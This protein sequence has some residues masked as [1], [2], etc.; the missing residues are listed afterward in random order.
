MILWPLSG[1]AIQE[2][3]KFTDISQ[4]PSSVLTPL[5]PVLKDARIEANVPLNPINWSFV[6]DGRFAK[7]CPRI[8]C[9]ECK[10]E[11]FSNSEGFG[12]L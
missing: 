1:D 9:N 4:V 3:V 2:F 6:L 7:C 5:I 12:E 8:Q 10:N 11:A